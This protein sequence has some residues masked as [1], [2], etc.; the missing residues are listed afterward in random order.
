ESLFG[1]FEAGVFSAEIPNSFSLVLTQI[2]T[3]LLPTPIGSIDTVSKL[4]SATFTPRAYL[5]GFG[6]SSSAFT[7]ISLLFGPLLAGFVYPVAVFGIITFIKIAVTSQRTWLFLYG[8][9]A[10]PIA[11]YIWRA[12]LWQLVVP[13]IK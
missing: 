6:Y 2:H 1:V 13:A 9:S 8:V 3:L 7:E 11:F 10:L 5:S 4:I 12:E